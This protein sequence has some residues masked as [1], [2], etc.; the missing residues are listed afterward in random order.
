MLKEV[1]ANINENF[2]NSVCFIFRN[3]K[4]S[5]NIEYTRFLNKVGQIVIPSDQRNISEI[6]IND[7]PA[8][9]SKEDGQYTLTYQKGKTNLL[10]FS[11]G[12]PYSECEKIIASIR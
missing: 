5:F 2:A 6:T 11:D 7:S 12:L 8:I 9:V 4:Q 10:F 1:D 3:G